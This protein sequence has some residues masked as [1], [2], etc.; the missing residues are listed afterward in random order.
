MF[1]VCWIVCCAV[2]VV[3]CWAADC[4][5]FKKNPGVYI[6]TPDWSK[7][8]VQPRAPMNLLHGNVVATFVDNYQINA[9]VNPVNGGFCI[10]INSVNAVVGYSNFD[11]QIDIQH[12]P[13]TC[14]YNAILAHE[15]KHI[16]AY[17]SVMDDFRGDLQRAL[18]TAADSVMPIF[19]E[20]REQADVIID[21]I[22]KKFQSHP[23]LILI[24][25][26]I[27]A[28]QEIR[29]KQIDKNEDGA[30]LKSCMN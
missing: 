23:E 21:T 26:K 17:L 25:Q 24:K 19:V 22:H 1:K 8:V 6:N 15:E 29:N 27:N 3:P 10:G 20:T 13:G 14:T 12:V 30:D 2:L 7:A 18:Y 16:K 4:L 5:Q 11:V 28:A 9:D